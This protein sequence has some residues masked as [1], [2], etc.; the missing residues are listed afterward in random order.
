MTATLASAERTAA[1]GKPRSRAVPG[2]LQRT[3][4]CGQHSIAGGECESCRGRPGGLQPTLSIG[5]AGDAHELEAEQVADAVMR[6]GDPLAPG[7]EPVGSAP[8][9]PP[10]PAALS[11]RPL[12]IQRAP[13]PRAGAPAPSTSIAPA[14]AVTPTATPAGGAPTTATAPGGAAAS[15]MTREAFERTMRRRWGVTSVVTGTQAS[16]TAEATPRG[17]VPPGG[18]VLPNWRSWD[19]GGASDV[20]SQIVETFDHFAAAIGG[21]PHVTEIVFYNVHYSVNAAGVATEVPE[22]GAMFGGGQLTLFR[23]LTTFGK[24]LPAARSNAAGNYPSV[25]VIAV[26]GVP[27][28]S[29]GAPIPYPTREQS[30]QRI[31]SHELGHGLAEAAMAQNPDTFRDFWQAVGWTAGEPAELYDVQAAGVA[32]ALGSTPPGTPAPAARI[33]VDDWNSPAHRE[34]PLTHYA[35]AGGPAE[36]FAE[37]VMALVHAPAL[38]QAR[39]PARHRFL[40][41]RLSAWLSRLAPPPPPLGDFPPPSDAMRRTA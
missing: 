3:C 22:V 1:Y 16:Q 35:V 29:P 8:P 7:L 33:T 32:A 37:S 11:R 41:Q 27:G 4:R 36:D 6:M 34:Q 21:A 15:G 12:G 39:S 9:A 19:P 13:L 17:G 26:G 30:V 24:W 28:Q 40:T 38:L 20:Y 31:V 23:S 5:R 14:P 25:P 2:L 18:I 10:G